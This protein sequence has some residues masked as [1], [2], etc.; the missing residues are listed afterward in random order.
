M[1]GLIIGAALAIVL[2][3]IVAAI[4]F[5]YNH[6]VLLRA[7]VENAWSQIDVQLKRRVDLIPNLIE[8]VKG[9]AKFEKSVLTEVTNARASVLGAKNPKELGAANSA[10]TGA[11]TNLFAVAEGYPTLKA[12][13]NFKSLQEELS[14]TENKI[15]YSRQF[16]NDSVM[17]WNS[18]ILQFP[19]NVIAGIVGMAKQ[20]DYFG[21]AESER[22]V[23][24]A[25]FSDLAK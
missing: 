12:N 22:A 13:E 1:L 16:Y 5:T 24:K 14:S 25:D 2:L 10:L 3:I 11:L 15:A 21:I 18:T 19:T 9:Y 8:T 6:L 17:I 7:R 23:V 20:K 4:I